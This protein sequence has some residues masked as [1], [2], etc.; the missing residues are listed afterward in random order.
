MRNKWVKYI[1]KVLYELGVF[2][3]V[4]FIAKYFAEN[5]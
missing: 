2:T 4:Y 5:G 3:A 1:L